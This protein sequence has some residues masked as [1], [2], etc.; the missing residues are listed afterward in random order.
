MLLTAGSRGGVGGDVTCTLHTQVDNEW[1]LHVIV[2]VE[3]RD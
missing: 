3:P 2:D 1:L